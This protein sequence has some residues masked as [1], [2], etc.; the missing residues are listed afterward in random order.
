MKNTIGKRHC[1]WLVAMGLSAAGIAILATRDLPRID[2]ANVERIQ[3]GWD[4]RQVVRILGVPAGDYATSPEEYR[5]AFN[6]FCYA[7][8]WGDRPLAARKDWITD[9]AHL[10]LGFNDCGQ[11][12]FK[13]LYSLES[14]PSTLRLS[15]IQPFHKFWSWLR[16]WV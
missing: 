16:S 12:N 5:L 13:Q 7:K 10:I 1:T 6:P 15:F 3:Y 2:D 8:L 9:E 4:E 11:V 14:A